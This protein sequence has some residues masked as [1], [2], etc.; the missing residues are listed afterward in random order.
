MKKLAVLFAFLIFFT[1]GSVNAAG[2]EV[3][4]TMFS[5]SNAQDRVW[6]GTFQLVWNDF[7]DKIIFNPVRFRDGN[8]IS[9]Q[10]LNKKSFTSEDLSEKSYYKYAGKVGKKTKKQITKAIKKKFKESSDLLDSLNLTPR[11]DLL[12]VYALLKKDFEFI[13]P[14]DKFGKSIF[15]ENQTAEYFGIDA[16]S[17]PALRNGVEVLF[18]NSSNDFAVSLLTKDNENVILYRNSA[19]KAFKLLYEDLQ[20]KEKM[21]NG[22]TRFSSVD[23]L[24][25]PALKFTEEK[26]FEELT[27]RRIMGTNYVI[28]QALET[29]KF[30]MDY[31]GVDLKSEAAMTIMT[32]SLQPDAQ[33]R[34]FNFDDT[35]VVFLK[36]KD[37]ENPYFAL[38][39]HD[40]TKFQ[41]QE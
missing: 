35:F 4:P 14:F 6:V 7:I 27:G 30:G 29:I 37:K 25:V 9:V 19:N 15:R 24:R 20:K 17:A 40:I 31:K 33:P 23:V 18:Y 2:I 21:F 28:S 3:Q 13:R 26:S 8:P 38:R 1:V 32:T 16:N 41:S 22:S 36:E 11:N 5:R 12:L 34:F 10:E 39:V